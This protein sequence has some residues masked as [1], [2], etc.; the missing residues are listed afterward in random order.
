MNRYERKDLL[1]SVA[2]ARGLEDGVTL[3]FTLLVVYIKFSHILAQLVLASL[4]TYLGM[5]IK[6]DW[7][8]IY[9]SPCWVCVVFLSRTS[10][11]YIYIRYPSCSQ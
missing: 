3:D 9:T 5:I 4:A 10:F 2:R 6:Y 8:Q 7:Y 11:R 1:W